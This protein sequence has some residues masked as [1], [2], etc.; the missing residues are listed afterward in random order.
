MGSLRGD[1]GR[2][3]GRS[4]APRLR[5]A[6]P[7]RRGPSR[8][9]SSCPAGQ[10]GRSRSPTSRPAGAD[11]RRST[12]RPPSDDGSS[13]ERGAAPARGR[14]RVPRSQSQRQAR[15]VRGSRLHGRRARRRP[16]L[17]DDARGKADDVP[18]GR[19]GPRASWIEELGQFAARRRRTRLRPLHDPLHCTGRPSH[20]CSPSGTTGCSA[21]PSRRVPAIPVTVSSTRATDS[22]PTRRRAGPEGTSRSGPSRS[23]WPR[24]GPGSRRRVRRHRP[25]GYVAV[26]IRVALHPSADPAT[27][28][29]WARAAGTFGEDAELSARMVAAYVR[30]FQGEGPGRRASP[31]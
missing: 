9:R 26:G 23:G 1:G 19:R 17:P 6:R 12:P 7:A 3:I 24:R 2:A 15:S 14:R 8:G 31:A 13:R 18:S 28:P 21:S 27:E 29:R 30:G 4:P 25:A 5:G 22:A 20:G 10:R 16:A 11:A